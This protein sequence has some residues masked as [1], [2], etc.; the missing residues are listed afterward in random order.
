MLRTSEPVNQIK[1]VLICVL[2]SFIMSGFLNPI[3][4]I[5]GPVAEAFDIPLTVAVAR[6]GYFTFGVFAGY[7]LSFHIFDYVRLKTV[8]VIG[9]LLVALSVGGLYSFPSTT[10]LAFFL[11]SIGLFMSVQ[12]CGASTWSAG[13]GAAIGVRPS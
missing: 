2:A 10:G 7:I 8:V 6:F 9:Y 13:Y 1:I 12:A 4:L 5:S 11:F 3:G